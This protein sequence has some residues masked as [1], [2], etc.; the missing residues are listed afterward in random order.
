LRIKSFL[1]CDYR[2]SEDILGALGGRDERISAARAVASRGTASF[3][4][5]AALQEGASEHCVVPMQS[6]KLKKDKKNEDPRE[7]ASSSMDEDNMR[8][9]RC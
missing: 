8:Q 7:A 6:M 2:T 9:K 4:E 3:K 5:L 1:S